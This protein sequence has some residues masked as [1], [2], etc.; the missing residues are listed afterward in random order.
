MLLI[1]ANRARITAL[2]Q[3]SPISTFEKKRIKKANDLL[4]EDVSIKLAT[5]KADWTSPPAAVQAIPTMQELS[6]GMVPAIAIR[7][8]F[9]PSTNSTACRLSLRRR[10]NTHW[11]QSSVLSTL[12][13]CKYANIISCSTKSSKGTTTG[14]VVG[15]YYGNIS[16]IIE[17]KLEGRCLQREFERPCETSGRTFGA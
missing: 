17:K 14:R 1:M 2:G 16:T 6:H 9:H 8:E 4:E 10:R 11:I 5:V 7:L 13:G 3:Y 12:S 15:V